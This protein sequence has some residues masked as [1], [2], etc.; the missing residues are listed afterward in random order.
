VEKVEK[1]IYKKVVEA[2]MKEREII[3]VVG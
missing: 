3:I 2:G 1:S